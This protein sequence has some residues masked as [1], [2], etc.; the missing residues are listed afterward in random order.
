VQER[1]VSDDPEGRGVRLL[2]PPFAPR[3]QLAQSGEPPRRE[4]P[5]ALDCEVRV[6]VAPPGR[7][8]EGG[9]GGALLAHPGEPVCGL[10][11][12]LQPLAQG[13][14]V[15]DVGDRV[16]LLLRR[17]QS[18]FWLTF[19]SATPSSSRATAARPICARPRRRAAIMV[20][21]RDAN[22]KPKSRFSVVTS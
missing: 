9:H 20:S 15:Q 4:A 16:R 17:D 12:R 22:A 14:E 3:V 8:L 6:G 7:G 11:L 13:D 5:R 18:S 1:L 10:E 21:K 19:V 2:G